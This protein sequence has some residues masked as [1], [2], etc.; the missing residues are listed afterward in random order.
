MNFA[1]IYLPGRLQRLNVF[2][3]GF[4]RLQEHHSH[5]P[6]E[7]YYG[8]FE[9]QKNGHSV[10][11]FEVVERPRRS[12]IKL[13]AENLLKKKYFPVKT[14]TG[15]VDSVFFLL[16]ELS[17]FDVVI[18]TTPGIA[19]SLAIW[20][21]LGR[22]DKPI[23]GIQSGI[24][25]YPL[26]RIRVL[27]TRQLLRCMW[28]QLYGVGELTEMKRLYGIPKD[29]IEV[30]CF[31]VDTTFWTP[32][33]IESDG[34]YVLCVGNDALRD[35]DTLIDTAKKS[36]MRFIVVT[37]RSLPASL[38]QNIEVISGDWNSSVLNDT[39][40]RDLYR[41]SLVV[42][43]PL[44][45]SLQPSGQSVTLQAMAC[46]KPVI[47]SCTEG[48]WDRADLG[49]EE[50]IIFVPPCDPNELNDAI[51]KVWLNKSLRKKI[52]TGGRQ[53]VTENCRI[54]QFAS[55]LENLSRRVINLE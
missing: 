1:F 44:K 46:G 53:Y 42:V 54:E 55:R 22:F 35:F 43:V 3:E 37:K 24:L 20:K 7:F 9:L 32:G 10:D 2:D 16:P 29:R 11:L 38:P 51:K 34:D 25:N 48:I 23:I 17:R 5:K 28:T 41:R 6:S 26:N 4:L 13:I 39:S 8:A 21:K 50:N 45:P 30:N 33:E 27:L 31:G 12:L 52:V 47:I 15:I 18:A 36:S 49:H 14:Y 19:F 40:L